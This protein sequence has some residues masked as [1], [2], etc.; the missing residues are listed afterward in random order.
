M[1]KLGMQHEGTRRR[2]V[3]KWSKFEDVELYGIL[4][5]DWKKAAKKGSQKV[6]GRSAS[7]SLRRDKKSSANK[8]VEP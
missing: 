4:Q 3:K 5:E 6:D 1:R 2:H 8:K 7:T